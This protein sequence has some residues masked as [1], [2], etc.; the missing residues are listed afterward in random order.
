MIKFK[1]REQIKD[2]VVE[3]VYWRLK[4]KGC[5]MSRLSLKIHKT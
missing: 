3:K 4:S 5:P 2:L 1:N